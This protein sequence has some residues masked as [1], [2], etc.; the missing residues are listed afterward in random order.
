MCETCGGVGW[1]TIAEF[2]NT[3]M[4]DYTGHTL[5]IIQNDSL[6]FTLRSMVYQVKAK[7]GICNT[8][9]KLYSLSFFFF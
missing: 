6:P 5:C 3:H 4:D 9:N 1:N 7:C 2:V 8:E